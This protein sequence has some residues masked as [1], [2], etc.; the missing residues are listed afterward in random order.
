MSHSSQPA[1]KREGGS[2]DVSKVAGKVFLLSKHDDESHS[3]DGAKSHV[4]SDIIL[5]Y[6]YCFIFFFQ[7]K[8]TICLN[9]S[10]Q[11]ILKRQEV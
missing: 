1:R 6:M 4:G 5:L 7:S 2:Y 9:W 3:E 8:L 10:H 11:P